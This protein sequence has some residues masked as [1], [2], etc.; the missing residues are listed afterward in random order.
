MGTV[1][2]TC[3]GT[4]MQTCLG[5]SLHTR[6]GTGRQLGLVPVEHFCRGTLVHWEEGV[7]WHDCTLLVAE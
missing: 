4:D 5:T 1:E 6:R 7:D 2:Q 3:L